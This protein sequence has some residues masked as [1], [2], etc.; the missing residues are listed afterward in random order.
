MRIRPYIEGK[1]YVYLSKWTGDERAHALWCANLIPFPMTKENLRQT[2]E[3]GAREW[4]D[5][6]YIATQDD[7]T[8]VGFFCYCV[9]VRDNTGFFKFVVVD[10]E[11]RGMGYG[12]EMLRLALRYAFTMTGAEAVQL[13][14][15]S[16]NPAARRCY[17]KA[18]FAEREVVKGAFTWRDEVWDKCNMVARKSP[19]HKIRQIKQ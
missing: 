2:L 19:P 6:A 4:T 13:N 10:S 12:E 15:F 5:S 8:P 9:D 14:V 11:K 1:D 18:G 7:G 17:E 16:G 3:T